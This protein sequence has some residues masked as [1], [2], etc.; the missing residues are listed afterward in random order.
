MLM[1][2]FVCRFFFNL[3]LYDQTQGSGA[4]FFYFADNSIIYNYAI[5]EWQNFRSIWFLGVAG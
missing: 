3:T 4:M 2:L 5:P 1:Y